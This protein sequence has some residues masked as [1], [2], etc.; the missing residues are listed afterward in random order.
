MNENDLKEAKERMTGLKKITLEES[1][2]VMNELMFEELTGK[3]E[4]YYDYEN[5]I[6]SVNLKDVKELAK[7]FL[8]EHSFASIIPE[9]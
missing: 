5:K 6:N 7:T 2:N 3:A 9:D 1:S 4:E 8:K